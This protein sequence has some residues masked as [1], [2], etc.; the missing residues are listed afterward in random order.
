MQ[1]KILI[2]LLLAL[3][4]AMSGCKDQVPEELSGLADQQSLHRLIL[5][6]VDSNLLLSLHSDGVLGKLPDL[7]S[8]GKDLGRFGPV[9]LVLVNRSQVSA[10]AQVESLTE[11]VLWGDDQSLNK[12]DPLLR[13]EILKGLAQPQWR[14]QV[15]SVIGV[16]TEGNDELKQSLLDNGAEIGSVAGGVVTL[17]ATSEVI[18]DILTRDDLRQLKK[19]MTQHSLQRL[20]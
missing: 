3:L 17:K 10:L 13:N 18:F 20:N 4:A 12:I 14:Q 1:R 5:L 16:F 15:Y 7:G 19:P 11:L 6:P 9:R 8:E 2:I